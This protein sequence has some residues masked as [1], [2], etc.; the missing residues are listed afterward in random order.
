MSWARWGGGPG[1]LGVNVLEG[2]GASGRRPRWRV[3]P[4]WETARSDTG[5]VSAEAAVRAGGDAVDLE[6]PAAEAVLERSVDGGVI[7]QGA[8]G[9]TSGGKSRRENRAPAEKGG[10]AISVGAWVIGGQVAASCGV[11]NSRRGEYASS[12]RLG[13][14]F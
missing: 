5:E 7:L 9:G 14:E 8:R 10:R 2:T 1:G 6:G 3:S 13:T 4:E 11:L 12:K